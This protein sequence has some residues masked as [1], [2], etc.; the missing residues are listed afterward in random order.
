MV[1]SEGT[2]RD[3]YLSRSI[4]KVQLNGT[5]NGGI[6]FHAQWLALLKSHAIFFSQSKAKMK[7]VDFPCV[8]EVGLERTCVWDSFQDISFDTVLNPGKPFRFCSDQLISSPIMI[9]HSSMFYCFTASCKTLCLKRR[10]TF[11]LHT[12]HGNQSQTQGPPHM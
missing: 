1:W 9:L 5:G 11:S 3:T 4:S 2:L 10:W 6:S 12:N 8:L 7:L